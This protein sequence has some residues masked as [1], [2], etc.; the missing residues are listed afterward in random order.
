MWFSPTL[1]VFKNS[2]LFPDCQENKVKASPHRSHF[3]RLSSSSGN[4][5]IVFCTKV[6]RLLTIISEILPNRCSPKPWQRI[7]KY[8]RL[9]T[10]EK[11]C[12]Q[13]DCLNHQ[14]AQGL[15]AHQ[16]FSTSLSPHHCIKPSSGSRM[17]T[18]LHVHVLKPTYDS[19]T[20]ATHRIFT[21][22]MCQSPTI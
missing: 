9:Y 16:Q 14:V 11:G 10:V 15:L 18:P 1:P 20:S 6:D 2:P 22:Q 5:E 3:P 7:T 17:S 12:R 21:P 8:T 13:I 19:F 4:P